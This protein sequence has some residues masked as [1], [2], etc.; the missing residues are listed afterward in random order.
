MAD[1]IIA[2]KPAPRPA[3]APVKPAAKLAPV[4]LTHVYGDFDD[5]GGY[6]TWEAGQLVTDPD[7]IAELTKRRAPIIKE[8][9]E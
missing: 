1:E 7:E 6:H 2:T 4:R 3:P 9:G 8:D 5:A